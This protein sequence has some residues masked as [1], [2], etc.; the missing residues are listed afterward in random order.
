[1][2]IKKNDK[3]VLVLGGGAA[4]GLSNIGVLKI[5]EEHF[6]NGKL[7]FDLVIGTSIGGLVGAAYCAGKTVKELEEMAHKF[8]WTEL[9]DV[10][11]SGTGLIRGDKLEKIIRDIIGEKTFSDMRIPFAL[12]TI[13]I[14]T[15]EEIMHNDGELVKLVRAS[16]SW[17]GIF[18]LVRIG[19]KLLADGG[20]RNS[21][22]TKFAIKENATTI[23]SVNP[24]FAVKNQKIDNI[25][26]AM[27]QSV[28][29]MGE[30]LNTYQSE[31]SDIVIKPELID[32]DQFDFTKTVYVIEQGEKAAR[33]KMKK[34]CKKINRKWVYA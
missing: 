9:L 31:N 19:D 27:I 14:E 6:G 23:I 34:V 30:E 29:I 8:T 21:I 5:F 20:V 17:P 22:P 33:E 11:I 3:K 4:R 12:T 28:Q 1:M 16:C 32:I 13:D 2:F 18:C 24:G 26:K 10:G 7:P 15:G 25:L